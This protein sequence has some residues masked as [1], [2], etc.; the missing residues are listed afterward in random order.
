MRS[1]SASA[2]SGASPL[3]SCAIFT[4]G[5]TDDPPDLQ[6]DRPVPDAVRALRGV[7]V[8][9]AGG[10]VGSQILATGPRGDTSY[11][12]P[13]ACARK[14]HLFRAFFRS[15]ARIDLCADAYRK[16]QV[17]AGDHE[18][19]EIKSRSAKQAVALR[20]EGRKP[21]ASKGTVILQR[22]AF[23]TASAQ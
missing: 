15:A 4:I 21:R 20:C 12:R 11:R 8:G 6:R 2:T 18:V 16:W 3:V 14:L 13:R 10:G 7:P 23:A 22:R 17:R 19:R 1:L 5:F 9:D